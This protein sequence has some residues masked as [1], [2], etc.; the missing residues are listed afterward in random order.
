MDADGLLAV[1]AFL[2]VRIVRDKLRL[3]AAVRTFNH[4][5]CHVIWE[6]KFLVAVLA[7]SVDVH[8]QLVP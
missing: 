4:I 5:T 3:L 8:T 1:W 2:Q 7:E 6:E